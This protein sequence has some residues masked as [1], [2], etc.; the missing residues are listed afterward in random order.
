MSSK[1]Q[2]V[3]KILVVL[4]LGVIACVIWPLTIVAGDRKATSHIEEKEM[5]VDKHEALKIA[6][7][8]ASEQYRDL[9]LYDAIIE[10]KDRNWKIDYELK[11]KRS[12]GGGPHY[13]ISSE[14]GRII[15]RRYE[16]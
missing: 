12:Q 5:K 11:D 15:S 1:T 16:Q 3:F 2:W 6:N 9:S 8:D 4:V 7:A 13:V 10:L 14:T